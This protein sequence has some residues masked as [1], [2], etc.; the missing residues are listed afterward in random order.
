MTQQAQLKMI[1]EEILHRPNDSTVTMRTKNDVT[2]RD[3]LMILSALGRQV[4]NV[5]IGQRFRVTVE[6]M[7]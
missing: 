5:A 3:S 6:V 7:E 4:A 2:R 1:V